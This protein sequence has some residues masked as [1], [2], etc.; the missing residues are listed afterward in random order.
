M[1]KLRVTFSLLLLDARD[2]V[3]LLEGLDPVSMSCGAGSFWESDV[4]VPAPSFPLTLKYNYVTNGA[5]IFESDRV[6]RV[7]HDPHGVPIRVADQINC[8]LRPPGILAVFTVQRKVK[9]SETVTLIL[10]GQSASQPPLILTS[11]EDIWFGELILSPELQ[12]P[13]CYKY[14][15]LSRRGKPVL[16]PGR[17]HVL[18]VDP[19]IDGL[20]IAVAD[21][22][23]EPIDGIPYVCRPLRP[24]S[25]ASPYPEFVLEYLPPDPQTA[26]FVS[27]DIPSL[28]SGDL[29]SAEAL[30]LDGAWFMRKTIRVEEFPFTF[31]LHATARG[32]K[33]PQIVPGAAPA[34]ARA[35]EVPRQASVRM[36]SGNPLRGFAVYVPLV[37]LWTDESPEVGDFDTLVAFARW[38]K[39]CRIGQIH[40]HIETMEHHLIDPVHAAIP[41]EHPGY[42]LVLVRDAKLAELSKL[43]DRRDK[44]D[45][46]FEA[47]QKAMSWV[48]ECCD[49]GFARWVQFFL[50]SQYRRAFQAILDLGVQLITDFVLD[51]EPSYIGVYRPLHTMAT[52]AHGV[53]LIGLEHW[54]QPP[55]VDLLHLLFGAY[56]S[57]I[58]QQFFHVSE[59]GVELVVRSQS[60]IEANLSWVRS[61][62]LKVSLSRKLVWFGT[63][64]PKKNLSFFAEI[65][66]T[67]PAALIA[68]VRATRDLGMKTIQTE[69]HFIPSTPAPAERAMIMPGYLSPEVITAWASGETHETMHASLAEQVNSTALS[70]TVYLHD[71]AVMIG[72]AYLNEAAPLAIQLVKDHCRFQFPESVQEM[73]DETERIT[74]IQEMLQYYN[75]AM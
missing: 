6:F 49:T 39:R 31:K 1:L 15:V 54:V 11:R 45:P 70:V 12:N 13:V 40:I 21:T 46:F 69:M 9:K 7:H 25:L 59:C 14:A 8:P 34:L 22:W 28:G 48:I 58:I 17:P 75:R 24:A 36:V 27:G 63:F 16:E 55:T 18:W 42:D 43:F 50:F 64:D 60:A 72:R 61:P 67:L 33:K 26:V 30:L 65:V 35:A 62:A 32:A 52:L 29:C 44:N 56:A 5:Q 51:V 66:P 10:H 68:D 3:L 47:F 38:A 23:A 73:E 41:Y 37:S 4:E 20:A 2:V 57:M 74:S 19:L 71:L 53:R